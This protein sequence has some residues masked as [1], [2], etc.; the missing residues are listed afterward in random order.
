MAIPYRQIMNA[1]DIKRKVN[2]FLAE[3]RKVPQKATCFFWRRI[4]LFVFAT[5][6]TSDL[7]SPQPYFD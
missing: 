2:E 3:P 4:E 1:D 6:V 5:V 7:A